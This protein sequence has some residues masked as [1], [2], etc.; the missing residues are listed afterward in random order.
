MS[1]KSLWFKAVMSGRGIVN[2]DSGDARWALKEYIGRIV[3]ALGYDNVKV[4]KHAIKKTGEE[5][6]KPVYQICLKVSSACIRH[7][8]FESDQP[9]H[10]PAILH[11]PKVLMKLISSVAGLLRGYMFE[12]KG[13]TG[14]K[15]KSPV[16][17]TD[18]EQTNNSV[19]TFD[20]GTQC[21][22]R[23]T[24]EDADDPSGLTLHY[25]E[26][27][28]ETVF[29]FE[30]AV[31]FNLLQF[32]SLSQMYDRL[33]VNPDY[34]T[35]YR[36]GLEKTL[37]SPVSDKAWYI[38]KTATN[39]L[40]E[41]GL[42]LS[43][44]QVVTLIKEFFQRLCG[45]CIIRGGGGYARINSVQVKHISNPLTDF[46]ASLE[47]YY[48]VTTPDDLKLKPEDVEVFYDEV[49]EGEAVALYADIESIKSVQ[50]Q[51][52]KEDK[53]AKKELMKAKKAAKAAEATPATTSTEE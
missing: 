34:L 36:A 3:K 22:P 50:E 21:A 40:P 10:N 5:N 2:Y 44:A 9:F 6:G 31:D 7:S 26:C 47:G 37:G 32:I 39:G 11:A 25:K 49:A 19:S 1:V 42:L 30:G 52:A 24:K 46:P 13:C 45:L 15:R 20:I 12:S 4:A 14:I 18:A 48:K 38:F 8:I 28:C 43:Q 51:K 27:I 41:E 23:E 17:I 53:A 29:E 16:L 33:A 35:E